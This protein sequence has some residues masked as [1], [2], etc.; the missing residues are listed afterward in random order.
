MKSV[1]KR[2]LFCLLTCVPA[3]AGAEKVWKSGKGTTWDCKKDPVVTIAHGKGVYTFKGACTSINVTGG[4]VTVTAES[5]DALNVMGAS[6]VV[7]IGS[8]ASINVTGAKNRVTWKTAPS[9]GT[10]SINN[11]GKDNVITQAG[12]AAPA[13]PAPTPPA[14]SAAKTTVDCS[15]QPTHVLTDNELDLVYTGTCDALSLMGNNIKVKVESVRAIHISGNENTATV[16]AAEKILVSGNDNTVTYK[17]GLKTAK[18]KVGNTGNG[19][20]IRAVK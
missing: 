18:P 20:T 2:I 10:P 6:N 5:T 12:G 17:K 13:Q 9:G 3:V 1:M 8:V 14:T 4:N 7:N 11:T 15:K 16:D 19:N